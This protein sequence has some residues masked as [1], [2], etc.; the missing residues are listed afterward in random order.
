M[1]ISDIGQDEIVFRDGRQLTFADEDEEGDVDE[2]VGENGD[3]HKESQHCR[4]KK[5]RPARLTV[6]RLMTAHPLV[7]KPVL[8]VKITS[9]VIIVSLREKP[10]RE[11]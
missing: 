1:K 11:R 6:M 3:L 10:V 7:S 8:I 9:L 2:V 4:R 5:L